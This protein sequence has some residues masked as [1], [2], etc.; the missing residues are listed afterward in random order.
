MIFS[1]S[2]RWRAALEGVELLPTSMARP[3]SSIEL[4][5]DALKNPPIACP[6]ELGIKIA[7]GASVESGAQHL[8]RIHT[9]GDGARLSAMRPTEQQ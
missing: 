9:W 3:Q 4:R 6:E 7:E 2:S 5:A 1:V 8:N